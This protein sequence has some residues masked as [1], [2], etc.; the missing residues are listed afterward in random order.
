MMDV[1]FSDALISSST[2]LTFIEV[3]KMVEFSILTAIQ[4]RLFGV[5][6]PQQGENP[7]CK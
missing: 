3:S 1:Y 5:L 7:H 6:V 4:S 2:R